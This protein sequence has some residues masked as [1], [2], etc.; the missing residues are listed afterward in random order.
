MDIIRAGRQVLHFAEGLTRE[1]LELDSMRQSAILYQIVIVGE[2]TKRL[3]QAYRLQYPEIPWKRIAGLLD[4]L[5]H[6]YDRVDVDV[7]W[8]VIQQE[9]PELLAMITPLLPEETAEQGKNC[10]D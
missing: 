1:Q 8:E 2:A 3:S 5:T 6:Q 7:I 9:M 4:I 10:T